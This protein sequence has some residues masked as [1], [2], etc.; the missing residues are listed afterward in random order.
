MHRG[1]FSIGDPVIYRKFKHSSTPGP[2]AKGV[3]PA[4]RGEDYTYSIDKFWVV[5]ELREENHVLLE[6]RR[7]KQHVVASTDPNLRHAR[8]WEKLIYRDRF[9]KPVGSATS[10]RA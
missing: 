6:T 2:R 9:P 7:G 8:W 5:A 1:R 3:D 4:P 10:T